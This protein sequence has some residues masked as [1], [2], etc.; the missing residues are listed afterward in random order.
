[1]KTVN[2]FVKKIQSSIFLKLYLSIIL[3]I[4]IPFFI[5]YLLFFNNLNQQNTKIVTDIISSQAAQ[6]EFD[7]NQKL[8]TC[9]LHAHLLSSSN[10]IIQFLDSTFLTDDMK[11]QIIREDIVPNI[12][13]MQAQNSYVGTVRILHNNPYLFD[14]YDYLFYSDSFNETVYQLQQSKPKALSYN[15]ILIVEKNKNYFLYSP[16]YNIGLDRIIG[17]VEIEILSDKLFSFIQNTMDSSDVN[18]IVSIFSKENKPIYISNNTWNLDSNTPQI[19]LH[20]SDLDAFLQVAVIDFLNQKDFIIF[21]IIFFVLFISLSI[22]LYLFISKVLRRLLILNESM[23]QFQTLQ[24]DIHYTSDGCDEISMLG[25]SFI[26][27]TQRI[28]SLAE[29][30]QVLHQLEYEAVY[31]SLENQ[32]NPHFLINALDMARMGSLLHGDHETSEMLEC[33]SQ[34]FSYNIRNKN[35]MISFAKELENAQNYV[36]IYTNLKG[37]NIQIKFAAEPGLEQ[38]ILSAQMLKFTFQPIIENSIVH[39]FNK[40]DMSYTIRINARIADECL[41]IDIEDNGIGIEKEKVDWINTHL[42]S[43]DIDYNHHQ[44]NQTSIG[45]QNIHSRIVLTFGKEYGLKLYSEPNSGTLVSIVLPFIEG[46][47]NIL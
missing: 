22:V 11:I 40:K 47:G 30:I 34:Y 23:C 9:K 36:N 32:L 17:L 39:G 19:T 12:Q 42:F 14:A 24:Q 29:Q 25:R 44:D 8:E 6:I 16:V 21:N 15:S 46:E 43:S 45:L 35:K 28:K 13:I 10:T 1:M 3:M 7:I 38:S 37:R 18:Q 41:Y 5:G 2:L 20:L 26:N 33:V 27:M 4:F 31:R